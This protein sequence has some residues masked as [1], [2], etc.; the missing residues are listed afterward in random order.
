M[1]G[2]FTAAQVLRHPADP[3]QFR[4]WLAAQSALGGI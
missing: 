2:Q 4:A 3:E 1:A